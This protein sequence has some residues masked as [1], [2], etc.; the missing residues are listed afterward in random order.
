MK[1][2]LIM[3]GIFV[4][5]LALASASCGK[6]GGGSADSLTPAARQRARMRDSLRDSVALYGARASALQAEIDT[7]ATQFDTLLAQF[8]IDDRKE[9]VE[10][11]RVARG[12]RGYDTMSRTGLLARMLEDGSIE[13]IATSTSAPF[14]SISLSSGGD[15]AN[16]ASVSPGSGL[17]YTV[18]GVTRVAFA[19]ADARSLCDF[20]ARHE[21]SLLTLTFHGKGT[22]TLTLSAEQCAMLS[23]M[24]R[25]TDTK[26][27]LDRL[28][29]EHM[30]AFNKWQLYTAEVN[31]DSIAA[32][33]NRTQ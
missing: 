25:A 22:Q 33:N 1:F 4:A 2:Q 3:A 11:Y 10:H 12:W 16:T 18:G 23:L 6:G 19:G 21:G 32:V 30:V 13:L 17:N 31:K 8:E 5:S 9:Y 15:S 14:T 7:L 28:E 26:E 24:A 20:A 29:R 27:R